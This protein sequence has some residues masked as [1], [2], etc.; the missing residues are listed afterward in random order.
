MYL[1]LI[2]IVF[3]VYLQDK[4][5]INMAFRIILITSFITFSYLHIMAQSPKIAL[6]DQQ[7]SMII[8]SALTAK[9]DLKQL[10]KELSIGLDAGLT[11]HKIKECLVHAYAYCGFPRSIRGLQT[12]MEVLEERKAKGNRRCRRGT[13]I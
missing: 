12:L 5:F 13:C 10:K 2:I 7:I 4:N 3:V 9:G 11:I 8:I 6:N 1:C